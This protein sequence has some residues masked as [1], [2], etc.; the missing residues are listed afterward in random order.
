MNTAKLVISWR[1]NMDCSYCCNKSKVLRDAFIPITQS[2][3][4][5]LPHND[6]ELTGGELTLPQEFSTT[7]ELLRNW[8]PKNRNYYFYTNGVFLTTWHAELL[9]RYGVGGINVGV[10]LGEKFDWGF[11][12]ILRYLDW[13]Q[14]VEVHKIL[15]IRLWVQDTDVKDFMY[16]LPFEI[17]IWTLGECDNITTDRYY[18]IK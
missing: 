12:T 7:T 6:F 2:Q 18:L 17:R 1:C 3:L 9:K 5:D 11:K 15:P 13:E 8:L 10:H 16:D 14:L 4:K